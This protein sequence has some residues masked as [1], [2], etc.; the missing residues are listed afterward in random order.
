[1]QPMPERPSAVPEAA[2]PLREPPR[3]S[4]FDPIEGLFLAREPRLLDPACDLAGF[5][6]VARLRRSVLEIPCHADLEPSRLARCAAIV[7]EELGGA[8]PART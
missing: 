7:R 8:P 6:E 5:P 3:K 1:M 4:G 2:S